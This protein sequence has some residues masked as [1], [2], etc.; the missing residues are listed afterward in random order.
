MNV[1]SLGMKKNHFIYVCL[2]IAFVFA[3]TSCQKVNKV[4]LIQEDELF[5]LNYGNF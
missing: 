5:T 1:Y 2:F 4:Q 3:F